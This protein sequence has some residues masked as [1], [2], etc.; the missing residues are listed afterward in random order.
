MTRTTSRD[1]LRAEVASLL[2]GNGYT[3]VV[4]PITVGDITLEVNGL[5]EGPPES[6]DISLI[7][8]RPDTR[9]A[10]LRL[11]WLV[12]RL[13][14]ALDA[15]SSRRTVTVVLVGNRASHTGMGEFMELARVLVVDG[16][17]PTPR[18]LGPLLPLQ[19]PATAVAQLDGSAQVAAAV[20]RKRH[21]AEL[22]RL[23]HAANAGASVVSDRYKAWID[24]SFAS[25]RETHD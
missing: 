6:L 3:E 15:A 19:L 18:M 8:D 11:F 2:R 24:E 1:A 7:A 17:L 9:E 21:S 12:Q 4:A 20:G 5:W 23:V 13:V 22:L 25:Y 16:S 10:T 14:R